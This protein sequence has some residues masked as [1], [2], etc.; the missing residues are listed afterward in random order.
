MAAGNQETVMHNNSLMPDYTKLVAAQQNQV[1]AQAPG[2]SGINASSPTVS[3]IQASSPTVIAPTLGGISS[4]TLAERQTAAAAAAAQAQAQAEAQAAALRNLG[5]ASYFAN[6]GNNS[7]KNAQRDTASDVTYDSNGNPQTL[8]QAVEAGKQQVSDSLT[9]WAQSMGL[10][11]SVVTAWG[12]SIISALASGNPVGLVV[13]AV[14]S[15]ISSGQVPNTM[16]TSDSSGFNSANWGNNS[17]FSNSGYGYS[18]PA[19]SYAGWS[20]SNSDSGD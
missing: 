16:D 17:G 10:P 12:P 5:G 15:A 7:V 1:T 13:Q 2:V 18:N 14:K 20:S 11:S 19:S 4:G 8:T 3:S 9:S 6:N